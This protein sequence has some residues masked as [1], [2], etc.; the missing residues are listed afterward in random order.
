MTRF[1]SQLLNVRPAEWPRLLYL[2]VTLVVMGV[3]LTWG[4]SIL[5]ASF[6]QQVG[7][8]ALP[9]FF[10]LKALV[11]LVGATI[12]TAFAD[13]VANARVLLGI[14]A[15]AMAGLGVGLA[16]VGL[17]LGR[18]GY[19]LLYLIVFVPLDDIFFA[20]WY[21]YV[22]DFYDTRAAKR[23]V[24]VLATA[25]AV[26]GMLGG[27]TISLINRHLTPPQ[28]V[29]VWLGLLALVAAAVWLMP[30]F[31]ADTSA[32]LRGALP[33]AGQIASP[34]GPRRRWAAYLDHIREGYRYVSRAAF[35]RWLA[36]SAFTLL[37]MLTALQY[38]T[39]RLLVERLQTVEQLSSFIGLL[40]GFTYLLLLPIQFVVLSRLIG[41]IGLG[42]AGLIYPVGNLAICGGLALAPSLPAAA[43]A[44]FS[45][46]NFYGII[47]YSIESLLYNAVPLR[48]KARARVFISGF[49]VPLGALAGGVLLLVLGGTAPALLVG[50]VLALS[51]ALVALAVVIRREYGRALLSMLEQE[52]FSFVLAQGARQ[53]TAAD[54]ATLAQLR[55][56]LAESRSHEL[57]LFLAKLLSEMGGKEAVD[58]LAQTTRRAAE[59]RTRAGILDVMQAADLRGDTVTQLY[60]D[61][62]NDPAGAVRQS[63]IAGLEQCVGLADRVFVSRLLALLAE[64]DLDVRVRALLTLAEAGAARFY[65]WPAAQQELNRL[66]ADA[67]PQVRAQGV[68]VLGHLRGGRTLAHALDYWSDPA[69]EVRLVAALAIEALPLASWAALVSGDR[70]RIETM[71]CTL[72]HDPVERVRQTAVALLC[73]LQEGADQPDSALVG[74]LT[75]PSLPVRSAAV[76]ALVQAGKASVPLV[77]PRLE[78]PDPLLR[79]MAAVTLSRIDPPLFGPLIMSTHVTGNL[80]AIYR[81]YGL[82]QALAP[83]ASVRSIGVL[84]SALREQNQQLLDEIFYLLAAVH[85]PE[86]VRL[87]AETLHGDATRARA[88]AL[89]AL[90]ALI[91]P[92]T[93]RLMAPLFDPELKPEELLAV[94]QTAWNM[95]PPSTAQALRQLALAADDPWLQTIALFALGEIGAGL[96]PQALPPGPPAESSAGR[97]GR[98]GALDLLG[99]LADPEPAKAAAVQPAAPAMPI[100][101][102]A[103]EAI[104]AEA[105]ASPR[106]PVRQAA[107]AARQ[108]LTGPARTETSTEA[109][110]LSTIEK[111]IFL[112]EVPF[113]QG[114]TVDQLKALANV[115][116]EAFFSEDT[117]IYQ[118]GDAGGVLYVV[119]DGRVGIEQEKRTGSSARLATIDA[120]SYFGEM[121]LFDNSPRSTVAVALKDTQTLR[122]R[123]EPLVALA[124]QNPDLSLALIN[125]LS[126]RLRETSDRVAELT[127]TRP[128]ELHKLYDQF[129]NS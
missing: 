50:L 52:D 85:P 118:P 28:I 2:Y 93:A 63:A 106:E 69:D 18:L 55:Q 67:A 30:R 1:F 40:M 35:L 120:H 110:M 12:Y 34:P 100:T 26:G 10:V 119:V 6:L 101:L 22:N 123:R 78:A 71:A 74:A 80:I 23:I 29:A 96:K 41:R 33:E 59:P 103:I 95:A 53:L 7:V 8:A 77:H 91:T 56:K 88:N 82:V 72:L 115:C 5:E 92:Q 114:M 81:H 62:L 32:A 104:L 129:E 54:P 17:R 3:G 48:V 98:R 19:P 107:L 109:V 49:M 24:P 20:H 46:T 125:V 111:V 112:K 90:E 113:F 31:V 70:S 86:A 45:R 116:E 47:G 105:Q 117:R 89:E 64:P 75:D 84:Q 128:R 37:L 76:E 61:S 14:L 66:L 42:N 65:Q 25:A 97:R 16:L 36:L 108:V 102:S 73:R 121:N 79:K 13:R 39:S 57:T 43:L 127:R 38:Y 44:Y 21:T 27:W 9:W 99:A 126:Q 122:L 4:A 11:A 87:I 51:A 124:R 94:S 83:C 60:Y 58:L 15:V 68:Q